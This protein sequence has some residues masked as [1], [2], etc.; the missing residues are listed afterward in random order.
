[1]VQRKAGSGGVGDTC[2]GSRLTQNRKLATLSSAPAVPRPR[3]GRTSRAEA[4]TAAVVLSDQATSGLSFSV[5]AA[6]SSA[7]RSERLR[8]SFNGAASYSSTSDL[9]L[10]AERLLTDDVRSARCSWQR[11]KKIQLFSW[12]WN[13]PA[14]S[15]T[16]SLLKEL[17]SDQGIDY[18]ASDTRHWEGLEGH[19]LSSG[20]DFQQWNVEACFAI[21]VRFKGEGGVENETNVIR[22]RKLLRTF[23][24]APYHCLAA[25]HSAR[26]E[27][28]SLSFARPERASLSFALY[29]WFAALP[30]CMWKALHGRGDALLSYLE[31]SRTPSPRCPRPLNAHAL[32]TKLKTTWNQFSW[33]V[34]AH[35]T[36]SLMISRVHKNKSM[37]HHTLGSGTAEFQVTWLPKTLFR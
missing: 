17:T 6:T 32:R 36:H 22:F 37:Q 31:W 10:D 26:P 29:A 34:L 1:M 2:H 7:E 12:T 9:G 18:R 23:A 11:W 16:P 21:Y 27:Q 5:S 4:T 35:F 28:A 24:A 25:P 14:R 15:M 13:I 20:E 30:Y 33:V 3:N 8:D 19:A